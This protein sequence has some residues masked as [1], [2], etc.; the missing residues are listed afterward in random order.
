[1]KTVNYPDKN[2]TERLGKIIERIQIAKKKEQLLLELRDALYQKLKLYS[3][4]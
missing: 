4:T 1:M 2:I 3:I